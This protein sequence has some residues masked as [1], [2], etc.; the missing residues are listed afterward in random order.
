MP[1]KI[2]ENSGTGSG[3]GT[4]TGSG[5]RRTAS[6]ALSVRRHCLVL[7]GVGLALEEPA[8]PL[9]AWVLFSGVTA[10]L[11][12]GWVWWIRVLRGM[13]APQ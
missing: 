5:D 8:P 12:Y 6:G 4:F 1:E 3:T 13:L 2:R 7:T 9:L 11:G 10:L